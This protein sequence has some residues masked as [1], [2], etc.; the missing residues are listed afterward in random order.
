MWTVAEDDGSIFKYIYIGSMSIV[1][2]GGWDLANS[3]LTYQ[4]RFEYRP[5]A[6]KEV[7]TG[8][9]ETPTPYD[10]DFICD[11]PISIT[12]QTQ[13]AES[14]LLYKNPVSE[15]ARNRPIMDEG[16]YENQRS[17]LF[18]Y[19][20]FG[21]FEDVVTDLDRNSGYHPLTEDRSVVSTNE[22]EKFAPENWWEDPFKA[23]EKGKTNEGNLNEEQE[24]IINAP[25]KFKVKAIDK[26]TNFDP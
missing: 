7:S 11:T 16:W 4:A 14:G 15:G 18:R 5:N 26:I 8:G 22:P 10:P 21:D 2:G 20:S 1:E 9:C 17:T 23:I 6:Q 19:S 24:L 25:T 12:T 13:P 3:D